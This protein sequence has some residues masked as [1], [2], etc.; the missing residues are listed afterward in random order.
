MSKLLKYKHKKVITSISEL[1][2]LNRL[3]A[4]LQ[5]IIFQF[6]KYSVL[7]LKLLQLGV[8][9][10]IVSAL[11]LASLDYNFSSLYYALSA[12][13]SMS[14]VPSAATAMYSIMENQQRWIDYIFC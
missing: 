7:L 10:L 3:Y 5:R 12:L 9:T 13:V 2:S 8:P 1:Q 11:P 4:I 6:T 14:V